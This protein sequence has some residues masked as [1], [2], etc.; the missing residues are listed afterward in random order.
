M[1]MHIVGQIGGTVDVPNLPGG[2]LL[3]RLVFEEPWATAFGLLIVG[4]IG[5][6]IAAR[7][8][9]GRLGG[10]GALVAVALG[11]AAVAS[12]SMV[13]TMR[14]RLMRAAREFVDA[15]AAG[16][17]GDVGGM[18]E[19]RV[20]LRTGGEMVDEGRDWVLGVVA[21]LPGVV[22]EHSVRMRGATVEGASRG[23]TRM[24][25]RVRGS[26][27]YGGDMYSSWDLVWVRRPE[28]GADGWWIASIECL[29]I[30]GRAPDSDWVREGSDIAR[31]RSGQ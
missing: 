27:A 18:L 11:A 20:T 15:A 2:P 29:S 1:A 3:D 4:V 22:R 24:T 21:G 12:G 17:A 6:I 25:V 7:N 10:I 16:R 14:E 19:E 26:G 9:R 8:G 28:G 13:E 23:R 5:G 30:F 31:G